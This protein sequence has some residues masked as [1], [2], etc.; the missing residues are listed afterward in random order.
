MNADIATPV[1]IVAPFMDRKGFLSSDFTDIFLYRLTQKFK[2]TIVYRKEPGSDGGFKRKVVVSL[3]VTPD[4]LRTIKQNFEENK[5]AIGYQSL[6]DWLAP[7]VNENG[8]EVRLEIKNQ[9]EQIQTQKPE[10]ASPQPTPQNS[11]NPK[12]TAPPP[13]DPKQP[14][15]RPDRSQSGTPS[16]IS[17]LGAS[18][19]I[20][21]GAIRMTEWMTLWPKNKSYTEKVLG[22][23]DPPPT[24]SDMSTESHHAYQSPE[25]H[26]LLRFRMTPEQILTHE[27]APLSPM[28]KT[29]SV[30]K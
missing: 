20:P 24:R 14:E 13:A 11:T 18:V 30:L 15:N 23:F 28:T 21:A 25:D 29:F 7:F 12:S 9:N 17:Q 4:G 10:E 2:T 26:F 8:D 22:Q 3:I 1:E 27:S 16:P 5:I 6:E 19:M